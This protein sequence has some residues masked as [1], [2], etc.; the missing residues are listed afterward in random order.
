MAFVTA[1]VSFSQ[2]TWSGQITI[3]HL[4]QMY[5]STLIS[6]TSPFPNVGVL[7]GIF[8]QNLMVHSVIKQ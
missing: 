8:I 3:T 7:G 5:L 6:V 2:V 4:S 1:K